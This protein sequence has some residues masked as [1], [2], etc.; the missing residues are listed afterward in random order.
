M[1]AF[2]VSGVVWDA[3]S[4]LRIDGVRVDLRSFSG[5]TLATAITSGSGSFLF[6][7]VGA[8]DYELVFEDVG[9]ADARERVE[10]DG[11]VFG[12]MVGLRRLGVPEGGAP[13]NKLTV[14]VRELSIPRKAREAMSKAQLL[15][16][17][18]D[19][20]GS[21]KQFQRAVDAYPNYYEALAQMGLAYLRMKDRAHAEQ[22]LRKSIE[23]SQ[24]RYA[25]AFSLLAAFFSS[26]RNFADAEEQARKAVELDPNSW[27][28]QSELAQALLG[29][30]RPAEAETYAQ[31]AGRLQ[32]DNPTI[33]LVLADIHIELRN[34]AALLEDL[35]GY[36]KLAPDGPYAAKARQQRDELQ[37]QSPGSQASSVSGSTAVSA[38]HP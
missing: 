17:K 27:H 1:H 19:Y 14:S 33:Y 10:V 35:N 30:G 22:S 18:S 15:Y 8:G 16:Q 20:P 5:G 7:N 12:L 11:P 6:N 31:A 23:V 13:G 28:A 37:Q 3:Q 38:A 9:Y 4:R 2:T 21:I 29:L 26:V 32:P 25:D 24:E 34:N 36:L